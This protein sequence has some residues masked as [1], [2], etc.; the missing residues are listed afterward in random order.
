M[1]YVTGNEREMTSTGVIE[2]LV[3]ESLQPLMYLKRRSARVTVRY[4]GTSTIGHHIGAVGIP[5]TEIGRL[6]ARNFGDLE[7]N[8]VEVSAGWR[9][10][11]GS[12]V[13]LLPKE[14]P[15]VTPTDPPRFLLDIHLGTLARRLRILGVDAAWSNDPDENA[16]DELVARA[17]EQRR[18]LLTRDRG[19][20]LRRSLPAGAYVRGNRPDDQLT[21]VLDRFAPPL[22]PFTRC[23][24]CNGFL[25]RVDKHDVAGELQPGTRRTY[26]DFQRCQD[27]DA[28]YWAGAHYERLRRIVSK[29]MSLPTSRT[30]SS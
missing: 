19:I 21:D 5:L 10:T 11:P 16:D 7:V 20:L 25:R 8:D 30:C 28:V 23:P 3:P 6:R 2:L 15:Q 13:S 9:P 29:N 1:G 24:V 26:Q 18:V 12:V 27:C 14:R 22:A 4:D 17:V